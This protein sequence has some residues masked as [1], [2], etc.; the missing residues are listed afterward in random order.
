MPA[1]ESKPAEKPK[2]DEAP[3][4]AEIRFTWATTGYLALVTFTMSASAVGLVLWV[5][6]Q[7]GPKPPLTTSTPVVVRG[8]AMTF[9]AHAF[10]KD[11]NK[12]C[13]V[14]GG[15]PAGATVELFEIGNRTGNPDDSVP[16]SQVAQMDFMGH[17]RDWTGEGNN[18]VRLVITNSCGGMLGATIA[19]EPNSNSDFYPNQNATA[20]D[21][22][23]TTYKMRF[24]DDDCESQSSDPTGDED[25]C[26]RA[27]NIY[28]H[29][30]AVTKPHDSAT[31]TWNCTDGE[32]EIRIV[33][34]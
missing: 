26:E 8:G 4:P 32:C 31:K 20:V 21:E 25:N 15:T 7:V 6:G 22:D 13:L 23:K 19:A 18:G 30:S 16:L 27:A 9:R 33:A 5:A 12:Q 11:G 28:I 24:M 1:E 14:I 29:A 2:S 34:Q 10:A 3:K 17:K